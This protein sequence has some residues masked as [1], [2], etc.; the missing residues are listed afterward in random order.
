M[1]R[2]IKTPLAP[3][4]DARPTRNRRPDAE[5]PD[6]KKCHP[7]INQEGGNPCYQEW[8]HFDVVLLL[9]ELVEL[10]LLLLLLLLWRLMDMELA[11][12]Q[13]IT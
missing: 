6:K 13:H 3:A 4:A 7:D 12:R 2:S 11:L 5:G 9:C 8:F 10:I 1:V